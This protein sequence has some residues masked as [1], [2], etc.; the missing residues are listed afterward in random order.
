MNQS[1]YIMETH[2]GFECC[3]NGP[4]WYD[5]MRAGTNRMNCAFDHWVKFHPVKNEGYIGLEHV[6]TH[7]VN[8]LLGFWDITV[9][10]MNS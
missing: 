10:K 1:V 5:R 8:H 4:F 7:L 9:Q 3:S 6:T 2:K